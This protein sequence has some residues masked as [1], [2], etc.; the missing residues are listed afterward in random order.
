MKSLLARIRKSWSVPCL[1]K[2]FV[3][4]KRGN[5]RA[6]PLSLLFLI[7]TMVPVSA[8]AAT[9][10]YTIV[11]GTP[12]SLTG[13]PFSACTISASTV[14]CTQDVTITSNNIVICTTASPLTV[15]MGS[16]TLNWDKN[17]GQLGE[18]ANRINIT[19][20]GTI[21]INGNNFKS[22]GDWSATA[23]N[24]NTNPQTVITGTVTA[25]SNTC[26]PYIV[27]K[28]NQT[29][30]FGAQTTPRAY[31]VGGTFAINPTATASS[32]LAVT[33]SS[34]TTNVCT[35]SGTTV[36]MVTAGTCTIAANQAGNTNYNAA[37]QV[38]QSVTISKANQTITFGA[39]TTPRTYAVGGTFTINPT[40]T[41]SSGLA[42][43]YSSTT[44]KICTV[45]GTTV[46]MSNDSGTCTIAANQAG[47]STYN[48]ATQVTQS[49]EIDPLV[50]SNWRM[51][52]TK[53]YAGEAG[54]V[55]NSVSGGT[56]GTAT[57]S[58]TNLPLTAAF[59]GNIS[60]KLCG[61]VDFNGVNYL[62]V[63]GLSSQLSGTASLSFWIKTTQIGSNSPW[64]APGV[65]GVEQNAGANDIFWGWINASG[66]IA[67]SKGNTL[68]AQSSSPIN[69]GA[70][71]HIV[72]TRNQSTGETKI[73]VDGVLDITRTS[74]TGLVTTA[75]AS[76]GR[77]QTPH[78]T[79]ALS[80]ALDEVKVFAPV[81]SDKQAKSIYDNESAGKNWDGSA[82]EC[83]VSG[84]HHIEITHPPTGQT[85]A[86]S[87]ITL[88]ACSDA[89]CN[90]PY[91]GSV[92][93]D[94]TPGT[95]L[96]SNVEANQVVFTG[97]STSVQLSPTSAGTITLSASGT[98]SAPNPLICKRSDNG[99]I[100][101]CQ[102]A[103]SACPDGNNFN[104]LETTL[105]PYDPAP[106]KPRLYTKL[107]GQAFSFDVVALNASGTPE[108]NYVVSGGNDKT[109][110][111]ELGTY[112]G[113]ACTT[114]F[115]PLSPAVT[116]SLTFGATDQGR[117]TSAPVSIALAHQKLCCR[118]TDTAVSK[119]GYST[120]GFS[121]RPQAV[122]LNTLEAKATAPSATST[123]K[124][125]AGTPF[126][127]TATTASGDGYSGTLTLD[128]NKL[129]AQ[130]TS[131]TTQ[132]SGGVV[133]T[134]SPGSLIANP[135][136]ITQDASYTEVGYLY[137]GTGAYADTMFTAIDQP[138]DCIPNSYDDAFTGNKIGCVI[139]NKT[140]VSLGRFIPSHF[141]VEVTKA[142]PCP[143]GDCPLPSSGGAAY[144][145]QGFTA[146]VTALNRAGGPTSN[147]QG[148]FDRPIKLTAYTAKGG[149]TPVDTSAGKLSN[150]TAT[151]FTTG[152]VTLTNVQYAFTPPPGKLGTP[153]N[154][155]LRADETGTNSDGVSSLRTTPADA[156][157]SIE[158]G[159]K[160]IQGR[161]RLSNAFGTVQRPPPMNVRTQYWSGSSW[162]K[163]DDKTTKLKDSFFTVSPT[164]T[165]LTNMTKVTLK[166]WNTTDN[167]WDTIAPTSEAIGP[168]QINFAPNGA[169]VGTKGSANVCAN[170]GVTTW[171]G[172]PCA[173]VTF[174]VYPAETRKTVH[175]RELY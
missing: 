78:A 77:I 147:Y 41:A 43:T 168:W 71:R 22:F 9:C 39:Q 106:G 52:E 59:P 171:L 119:I 89:S 174:G 161:L 88:K 102:I 100:S 21:N 132:R 104:C 75:F 123:D 149:N 157:D 96:V 131:D 47:D 109:V 127:L 97:G 11:A 155:H 58:P 26:G 129:T 125:I 81:L 118:V 153:I 92:T 40:A 143:T 70:W 142:L 111:V 145:G 31:A 105:T 76:L 25:S 79:G 159:I 15:N 35:V 10:N 115:S 173:K 28:A 108:T 12:A 103:V 62:Q 57:R 148:E 137:L 135:S 107:A 42:V 29:I 16:K 53:A 55:E 160:I 19:N 112:D 46:S 34:T 87:S 68:G 1:L 134:L 110:T 120:D 136:A 163:W 72:L 50:L 45:S 114:S 3:M 158:D 166:N 146:K 164:S 140:T 165:P 24:C 116:Q 124:V 156:S 33:Y 30:T 74:A 44:T 48:A 66:R 141:K 73:Y 5:I 144:A 56:N 7:I 14:T 101:N 139:G 36:T 98:P 138:D 90:T 162:I 128:K 63:T 151:D 61:G 13:S 85:C 93:L 154:I 37:P 150:N 51:D 133:G 167:K 117:K 4:T 20:A 121:V 27:G 17:N 6:W 113:N 83:P 170:L 80:G 64:T 65:T 84:P 82:R 175:T 49:V 18:D 91:T 38:T 2:E 130:L 69:N 95:W 60:G 23:V 169:T 94:L 152:S 32:G 54:E 99:S 172:T 67:V 8:I 126:T 86:P 122:T